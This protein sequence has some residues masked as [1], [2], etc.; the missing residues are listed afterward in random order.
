MQLKE[1]Y[2][3]LSVECYALKNRVRH[4]IDRKNWL[5]DG[6]WKESVLRSLISRSSPDSVKVGRG[7]VV[8]HDW[9]STQID[10]LLYDS[11]HPVLYRDGDLVFIS[12]SACRGV[13]EVK[14]SVD[15]TTFAKACDKLADNAQNVRERKGEEIFVGIFSYEAS[16]NDLD[17][18]KL[19]ELA[20]SSANGDPLRIINHVSLGRSFFVRY[21]A[22]EPNEIHGPERRV[23][24][25]GSRRRAGKYQS[26]HLYRLPDMAFGYFIHNALVSM[27]SN[28]SIE[29]ENVYFPLDG[30]ETRC[31]DVVSFK[32]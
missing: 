32:P 30:K 4:F 12:P 25:N 17:A 3:S 20:K 2:Q 6:E 5:T 26:W 22:S 10:I 27:A 23:S 29:E 21:W 9:A 18:R 16:A 1:Y 19:L 31:I 8:S 14:T 11:S 15:A 28:L 13:I 7:F 24:S